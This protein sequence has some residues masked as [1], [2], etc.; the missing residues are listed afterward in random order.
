M[1]SR[2]VVKKPSLWPHTL[3][4]RLFVILLTGLALAHGLSFIALFSE[5]YMTA[6]SVMFRTLEDDIATS[7][8]ILDRLP[9]A[10]RSAWLDQLA[11][12]SHR[13]ILGEGTP[14][15]AALDP[16][17]A[18]VA[19]KIRTAIGAT[20]PIKVEALTEREHHFQAHLRLSDG[21]PLTIDV[22]PRGV[23]KVADW[24]PF[25]LIAQLLLLVI[26]SWIAVRLA[27]RPLAK[28][29]EAADTLDPNHNTPRL[30]E[31]GPREVAHAAAAFNAMRDRI[32][33]YLEE[34]VQILAAISHD[35]QTPITRMKLRAEM[36]DD[37]SDRTKLVQD[38]EEVE[39]LVKEGV[40]YARSA[41]GKTEV[42]SRIDLASFVESLAY[43]YQDTGKKVT[44]AQLSG[45][46]ISTR[47]FALRRILT[48]LVDNALKF[49]G[50]AEI[51]VTR[52]INGE[53]RIKV[54]DRGPGIPEDQ[55]EKVLQPFFRLEESRNRETGGTGLGLAI[56]QQLANVL[57]GT[58]T[59]RNRQGGGL[60]AEIALAAL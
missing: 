37:S 60:E 27:I 39:R 38:L 47:P 44:V 25:V 7:V 5:R 42:P 58:L 43:D 33:Q 10:E 48:N 21:A 6:K 23:M 17:E 26:C 51:D 11:R 40:A 29:A 53:L 20:Y 59:L 46:A 12:G 36:A 2:L 15:S 8:A 56:A 3:R 34:R 31:V 55:L 4:A 35:L 13:F 18:E 1:G 22:T 28:L 52:G 16:Q 14:G 32:A 49:G 30:S 54:S 19:S 9:A 41:H 50:S 57:G 45:G 24:L